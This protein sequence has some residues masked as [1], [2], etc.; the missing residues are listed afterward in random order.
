MIHRWHRPRRLA[1]TIGLCLAVSPFAGTT[2]VQAAGGQGGQSDVEAVCP[3]AGPGEFQCLALRHTGGALPDG[4]AIPLA[5]PD[6]LTPADLQDAYNLPSATEG[7]GLTVAI[8]DAYDLPTAESDLAAYRSYFGLPACTT[9]NGCFRKVN[10]SGQAGNYP[11]A[12]A[13][14]G[15]EIALDMDMV[16]AICPLCDILLV[17]ANDAFT[18]SLGTAVDTAV[19]L[20]AVAVSNSYGGPEAASETTYDA[21][22]YNHPGVA[23]V[24][25]TG[26]C[27]YACSGVFGGSTTNKPQYPAASPYVVAV[28]G[29]SLVSDGSARGWTETAWGNADGGAGSGCSAYEAKPSWQTDSGCSGRTQ[30]DVSAVADPETGVMVYW[31]GTMYYGFGGTSAAAPIVAATFALA[32]GPKAGTYPASYLYGDTADLYD[33]VGGSN[34]VTYSCGTGYLCNG[35]AGYDGPTGLGTPNGV[36][37]FIAPDV[38]GK[39]TGLAGVTGDQSISLSW[40]APDDGGRAIIGY[41]VTEVQPTPGT[42]SCAMTGAT[43][44]LLGTLT[45]GVSYTFTVHATNAVGDGPES[46]PSAPV[47]PGAVPDPPTGVAATAGDG[48]AVVT[49]SAPADDGG[50]AITAYTVTSSPGSKTCVWSSGPLTCTVT[51]LTNGQAYTFTAKAMN[52]VGWSLASGASTPVTPAAP[53]NAPT[54]VTASGGNELAIVSWIAPFDGGSPITAY[55]VT[56]SPGSKTCVWSSGPLTCTVTGLT[57][58]QAY[59]FTVH[60]TNGLGSSGES[61]PSDAV[62]PAAVPDQP[63]DVAATPG[64]G[65]ATVTWAAAAANGTEISAYEVVSSPGGK[66]CSWSSGPLSCTVTGLTNGQAYTFTVRA[67]NGVGWGPPSTA[68]N[69]VTP[70]AP[71][72]TGAS[73]YR[74][75]TPVRL[76]D[77]RHGNG[78]S[79]KLTANVPIT[80]QIA[81]RGGVPTEATAVTASLTV[82]DPSAAWAVY[83]GPDPVAHPGSST[84]NFPAHQIL[85]NGLTVALSAT[86]SLSATYMGPAGATT[87]LVFDVTG[88]YVPGSSGATYHPMDPQRLLDTRYQTGLSG[89]FAANSPRTFQITG[90]FGIPAGATAVTGNLT[91]VNS[92]ASWAVY[93]GPSPIAHPTT[94]TVNFLAHQVASNNVTVSLGPGGTLAATYMGPSGATTDLVFDVTGYYTADASGSSFVPIT[95]FRDLDTRTGSGATGRI[96]VGTP[97]TFA[98]AGMATVPLDATGVT[99]NI[100]IVDE[101]SGWAI[102]LGPTAT[103][104][105]T[106]STI[107]FVYGDIKANGVTVA[108]SPGGTLSATYLGPSGASTQLVFDVTGY[109]VK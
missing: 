79:G 26:D 107:N 7:A 9:A 39:P 38:P 22:Y 25:S 104:T 28:G 87:D 10:Q 77:T 15:Q 96:A 21:L 67:M 98:V 91:V 73:T 82:V 72:P 84:I 99:G 62:T 34:A 69:E 76:L 43:S 92:T 6:M 60:A 27:G 103:T 40:T 66:A 48:S 50:S 61:A 54:G 2:P 93:L 105:P 18:T 20:G 97:R 89:K 1:A 36:G 63:S 35:V 85:S 37:A 29:T 14:W 44:C 74:S 51:G 30:A 49:W 4:S 57:N 102:F 5:T 78:H 11:A 75:V 108:L 8:V 47:T 71:L 17:E 106:T 16:S 19:S 80:F 68:S 86:G 95:P 46:D 109:F 32:G 101:T 70:A 13:G 52:G 41:T 3:A 90:R 45:N 12:N 23:I 58:G 24:A 94:S 42:V 33:V 100:T 55:T 65:A 56:S 83:V 59:T 53:P 64:I 31:N 88:Y 81:G